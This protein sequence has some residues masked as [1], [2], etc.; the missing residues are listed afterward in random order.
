MLK[1]KEKNEPFCPF[2]AYFVYFTLYQS[3]YTIMCCM[4][5]FDTK[6]AKYKGLFN[7]ID[8][9]MLGR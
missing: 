5:D 6:W 1:N 9:K 3:M 4:D 8:T 7:N 2:S